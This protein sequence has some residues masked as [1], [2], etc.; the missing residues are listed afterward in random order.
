MTGSTDGDGD[1]MRAA[2]GPLGSVVDLAA[3]VAAGVAAYRNEL[4]ALGVAPDFHDAMSAD[5][6]RFLQGVTL[7]AQAQTIAT[8]MA[9]AGN[10]GLL[11][12]A[13]GMVGVPQGTGSK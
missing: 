13:L 1:E 7:L 4:T 5:Y 12:Y 10:A 6:A 2:L 3:T 8:T 9:A 11:A